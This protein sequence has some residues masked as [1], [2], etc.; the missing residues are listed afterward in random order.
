MLR[1]CMWEYRRSLK[2]N[3]LISILL[4]AT[5]VLVLLTIGNIKTTYRYYKGLEPYLGEQGVMLSEAFA[6]DKVEL[7]EVLKQIPGV[8]NFKLFG[9]TFM[10]FYFDEEACF[11]NVYLYDKED[12]SR[13]MP[14]LIEGRWMASKQADKTVVHVLV[15]ENADN[16]Q[17]G[18]VLESKYT[19]NDG[20][21]INIKVKVVGKLRD[22]ERIAGNLQYEEDLNQISY[23]SFY[24]PFDSAQSE[25]CIFVSTEEEFSKLEDLF[26]PSSEF[27]LLQY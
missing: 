2:Q 3:F 21:L 23:E 5:I 1:L 26:I 6:S 4:A 7:S 19:R 24:G 8:K 17:V 16:I 9:S 11:R 25:E 14:D 18:D 13:G 10:E 20:K 27:G 12:T 15:S 22:G